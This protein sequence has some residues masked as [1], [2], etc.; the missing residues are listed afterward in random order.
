MDLSIIIPCFNEEDNIT[1]LQNKLMPVVRDLAQTRTIEI[2]F[3]DDGSADN[4]W[5]LMNETFA[6]LKENN[7]TIRFEKH[8]RNLGLGAAIRTGFA[9]ATGD[10]IVTTD[11]DGTYKFTEIPAMLAYMTPDIDIVTASPY[12]PQ[13][14]VDGVPAYRLILSKGSSFIYRLIVKWDIYCY[15]ALF[16]AYRHE[17][18]DNIP[19]HADGYLAGTEFMVKAMQAGYRVAE[20]PT[21]LYRRNFGVS[22]A[23]I[24]RTIKAHLQFQG[25]LLFNKLNIFARKEAKTRP[26]RQGKLA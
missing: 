18:I 19:F 20:Y 24:A 6:A 1:Q 4:T 7:V 9:A 3:V 25:A 26:V 14:G 13:G 21:V 16:R 11:S 8:P 5:V 23:R 17:V 12:H 2:V 15:T 22:K 10:I